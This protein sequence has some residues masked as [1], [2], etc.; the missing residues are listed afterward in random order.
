MAFKYKPS[1]KA[2]SDFR[3]QMVMIEQ[4]CI[5]NNI[6]KSFSSDSYYF[7]IN[8]VGYRVSNHST[9][10]ILEGDKTVYIHASKTRIM[11]I[12]NNLVNGVKLDGRGNPI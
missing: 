5:Q 4:F 12:Y 2:A 8:H 6:S 11:E 7:V 10:M 1:K 3:D 9:N